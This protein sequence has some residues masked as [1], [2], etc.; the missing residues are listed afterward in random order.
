M[1]GLGY[2][3]YTWSASL[4]EIWLCSHVWNCFVLKITW[5][6]FVWCEWGAVC[7]TSV[8]D[9]KVLSMCNLAPPPF[10]LLL[11]LFWYGSGVSWT[12]QI[13]YPVWNCNRSA[14]MRVPVNASNFSFWIK[15]CN[16]RMS[17]PFGRISKRAFNEFHIMYL[18]SIG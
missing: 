3:E 18:V 11:Y 2:G 12:V 14:L 10:R 5:T 8:R 4:F 17:I 1:R 6:E 7:M 9:L 15:G 13:L 16:W